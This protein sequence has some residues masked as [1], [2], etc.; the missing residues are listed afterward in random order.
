ML[1]K[2]RRPVTLKS[3]C[4]ISLVTV[5]RFWEGLPLLMLDDAW[6]LKR[7]YWVT[8]NLRVFWGGESVL[9]AC[10]QYAR[11]LQSTSTSWA[12]HLSFKGVNNM[13][14]KHVQP[15]RSI[16]LLKALTL[17]NMSLKHVQ[18]PT[19][20]ECLSYKGVNNMSGVYKIILWR[21]SILIKK[22]ITL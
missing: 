20:G 13:S 2:G 17:N 21:I 11:L 22:L 7:K 6:R 16:C 3:I 18:R 19:W 15:G 12:E 14:F 1:E 10:Q 5:C 4:Q 9:Q 8:F